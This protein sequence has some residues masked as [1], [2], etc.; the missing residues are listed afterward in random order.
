M[1]EIQHNIWL[2]TLKGEHVLCPY[3]RQEPR[4]VLDCGTGTG[5]WAIEYGMSQMPSWSQVTC[6]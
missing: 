3:A 5:V 2:L 1:V 6:N 4:R